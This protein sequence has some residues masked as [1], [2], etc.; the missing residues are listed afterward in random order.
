MSEEISRVAAVSWGTVATAHRTA[1]RARIS[2][3]SAPIRRSF[4]KGQTN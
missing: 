3:K 4:L 1:S 2:T